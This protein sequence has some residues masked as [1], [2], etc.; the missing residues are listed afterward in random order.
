MTQTIPP[1]RNWCVLKANENKSFSELRGYCM[2]IQINPI[3]HS[4][5]SLIFQVNRC[6]NMKAV[7]IS[8]LIFSF[9]NSEEEDDDDDEEDEDDD[10]SE[11]ETA[12]NV[13]M[14]RC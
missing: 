3:V 11:E 5:H 6:D 13:V 10:E 7:I 9:I 14:V 4:N 12:S 8:F 1:S 2:Y